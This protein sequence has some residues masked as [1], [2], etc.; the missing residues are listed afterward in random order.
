MIR[1]FQKFSPQIGE[2]V[3]LAE[4][5]VVIGNVVLEKNAN[6]WYGAVLRGDHAKIT[7]GE[8]S[9]VQDNAVLHGADDFPVTL[10]KM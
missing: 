10:G 5:A 3:F 8:G 4:T 7:V 6:I 1:N 2:G 9:N